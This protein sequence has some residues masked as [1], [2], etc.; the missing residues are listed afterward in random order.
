MTRCVVNPAAAHPM[1][2]PSYPVRYY[3]QRSFQPMAIAVVPTN[4]VQVRVVLA[5]H[6]I[7]TIRADVHHFFGPEPALDGK[8]PNIGR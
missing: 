1:T 4:L 8:A 7:V 6:A 5:H 2:K 3:L